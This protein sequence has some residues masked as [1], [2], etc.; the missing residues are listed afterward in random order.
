ML[1]FVGYPHQGRFEL[2]RRA[3]EMDVQKALV[4]KEPYF[5]GNNANRLYC[6]LYF[7]VHQLEA[8]IVFEADEIDRT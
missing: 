4:E 1:Y 5:S 7:S 6:P 3:L 2:Q 8:L